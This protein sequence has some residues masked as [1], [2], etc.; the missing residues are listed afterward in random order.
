MQLDSGQPNRYFGISVD[1]EGGFP[2]GAGAEEAGAAGFASVF[3]S[4]A[5]V[6]TGV[7]RGAAGRRSTS[8]APKNR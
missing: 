6:V 8:T 3:V 5:D 1:F 4:G 7:S 2:A